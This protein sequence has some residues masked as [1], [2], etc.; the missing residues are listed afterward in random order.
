[1]HIAF[2]GTL[3]AVPT[4]DCEQV[5][6]E[7]LLLTIYNSNF[8]CHFSTICSDTIATKK[9]TDRNIFSDNYLEIGNGLP[10]RKNSVWELFGS[11]TGIKSVII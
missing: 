9:I 3:A 2:V 1:M 11:V 4:P 7:I 5:L 8:P 6:N 10:T